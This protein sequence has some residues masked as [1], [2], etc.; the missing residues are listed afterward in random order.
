LALLICCGLTAPAQNTS[1]PGN[2][3]A[4]FSVRATHLLGFENV[5]NNRKG[6]LSIQDNTLQFQQN[7]KPG[8]QLKITSVRDVF[9]GEES[10]QVG[11]VPVMLGKAAVPFG[12][13]R[14]LSLFTHKK[15]ETVTLE[16]VDSDGGVHG[17]IFRLTKGEGKVVKDELAARGVAV[18]SRE[19][20]STKPGTAEVTHE[21]K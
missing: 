15:Y 16:Y 12:G 13:G 20:Q 17:A 3:S 18:S 1:Q 19:D 11:G 2:A 7:G 14:V 4:P 21:N 10:K 8:A 6:T 5:K 9:V